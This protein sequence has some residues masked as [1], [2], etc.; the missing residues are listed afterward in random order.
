MI[1]KVLEVLESKDKIR[2]EAIK[3][4]LNIYDEE[5]ILNHWNEIEVSL[6]V[7]KQAA[8]TTLRDIT[9]KYIQSFVPE[10]RQINFTSAKVNAL[11]VLIYS[12]DQTV[13]DEV[14][15]ILSQ[16]R[17]LEMWIVSVI[18]KFYSLVNKIMNAPDGNTVKQIVDNATNEYDLIP[19]PSQLESKDIA[20]IQQAWFKL[21]L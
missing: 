15:A 10:Y 11:F 1:E 3:G 13:K 6:E 2:A 17:D 21:P 4:L 20:Y 18:Q 16:I 8:I 5:Y 14:K 9:S 7:Y 12:T 19:K